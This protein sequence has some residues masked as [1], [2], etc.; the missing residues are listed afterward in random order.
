LHA[1]CPFEQ[2]TAIAPEL[3]EAQEPYA[4]QLLRSVIIQQLRGEEFTPQRLE[5]ITLLRQRIN[6]EFT[7]I[8][9]LEKCYE[10]DKAA[11]EFTVRA[12]AEAAAY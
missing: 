8:R 2:K 9:L 4:G 7:A 6:H 11:I 1:F 3:I 10:G 5:L 12:V